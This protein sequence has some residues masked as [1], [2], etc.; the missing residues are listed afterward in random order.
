MSSTHEGQDAPPPTAPRRR[1]WGELPDEATARRRLHWW[2]EILVIFVLYLVYTYVRNTFGSSGNSINADIDPEAVSTALGHSID[3]INVERR[4][5]M[6]FEPHLQHWY[7]N[8]PNH[9]YIRFW[10]VYYGSFHFIIPIFVLVWLFRRFPREYT[11]WRNSLTVV[12][13]LG[14][15]G[16]ASFSVMPPR[17]LSFPGDYGGCSLPASYAA[18]HSRL[19]CRSYGIVDTL[20]VY[21][22]LWNFG[23]STMAH[24]S[25]QYAAMPSLHIG[26]S[27]WCAVVLVPRVKRLWKK[28]LAA[29]Y[30][31]ATLFGI[32][33]TGN[34]FWLDALGGLISLT[35]AILIGSQLAN[36]M[37][38]LADRRDAKRAGATAAT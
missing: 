10:N 9:G 6:F 34:H 23:S 35:V 28:I 27:S 20:V 14:L 11:T 30:P 19:A 36:L 37:N 26:W 3:V 16:F 31:L 2:L 5:G 13:I 18:A 17:L 1:P 25:N 22:G 24:I 8:L 7:L 32:L 12:T 29:C 15:I 21:G 33:V 4:L 38:W